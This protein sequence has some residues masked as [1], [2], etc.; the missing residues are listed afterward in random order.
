MPDSV[1]TGTFADGTLS[2]LGPG[3]INITDFYYLGG[4]EFAV[5]S[6]KWP[7]SI[8]AVLFLVRP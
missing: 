2:A 5:G 1:F 8:P 3:S 7:D 6:M 4:K